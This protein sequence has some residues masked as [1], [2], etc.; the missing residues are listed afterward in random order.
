MKFSVKQLILI[1]VLAVAIVTPRYTRYFNLDLQSK[2]KYIIIPWICLIIA[3]LCIWV[4]I[5]NKRKE[6]GLE[7]EI[8]PSNKNIEE[9]FKKEDKIKNIGKNTQKQ[10]KSN[11]TWTKVSIDNKILLI[12]RLRCLSPWAFEWLLQRIF[13]Y[14]WYEIV[15]WPS[16]LWDKPQVDNW[17]DLIVKKNNSN[18]YVQIKKKISYLIG[19]NDLKIFK[20]SILS[21]E[22]IYITTSLFSSNAKRYAEKNKIKLV[23]YNGIL[24]IISKLNTEQKKKIEI[25]INDVENMGDKKYKPKTCKKCWA[26]IRNWKYWYY[27]LNKYEKN[28][29]CWNKTYIS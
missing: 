27:C 4:L 14:N 16:Y 6:L 26:P 23:D 13:I 15:E 20:G 11:N 17:Y 29:K 24:D 18:I 9:Q 22:W 8:K 12:H 10:Y 28:K 3:L 25:I 5:K 1:V 2:F 7:E 21:N 19:E